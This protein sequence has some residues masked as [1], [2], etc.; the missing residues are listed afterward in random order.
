MSY[1]EDVLHEI[2]EEVHSCGL[3]EKFDAQLAK[4][5]NQDK[6]KFKNVRERWEYA[7]HRIKGGASE[8]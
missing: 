7:L 5:K 3:K 8:M 6:H 1:T 4:M 2:Y